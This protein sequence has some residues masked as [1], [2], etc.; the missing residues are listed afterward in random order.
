[1]S[2][3]CTPLVRMSSTMLHHCDAFGSVVR[4][5][6]LRRSEPAYKGAFAEVFYQ[7]NA[8]LY[9][10]SLCNQMLELIGSELYIY[11]IRAVS[12]QSGERNNTFNSRY[13]QIIYFV[14]WSTI[15]SEP[16]ENSGFVLVVMSDQKN[17][18]QIPLFTKNFFF[19]DICNF[20]QIN[21]DHR[22]NYSHWK[23]FT[24]IYLDLF[25]GWKSAVGRS[26]S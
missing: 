21:H 12:Y 10:K 24:V 19:H 22:W 11:H 26:W 1:M 20:P 16:S 8:P 17:H 4:K 5:G 9:W 23:S 3:V 6:A 13:F 7:A 25:R 18:K 15:W 2:V 14:Y